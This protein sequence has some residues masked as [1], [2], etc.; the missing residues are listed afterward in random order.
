LRLA[1]Q[2]L[3]SARVAPFRVAVES[4]N[5]AF[6]YCIQHSDTFF[7]IT[8]DKPTRFLVRSAIELNT[9]IQ[10]IDSKNAKARPRADRLLTRALS[11][12][13]MHTHFRM[14]LSSVPRNTLAERAHTYVLTVTSKRSGCIG[15][16]RKLA[17]E[18][19]LNEEMVSLH[20]LP[21][22]SERP[23]PPDRY[24]FSMPNGARDTSSIT[25]DEAE[26][27]DAA[28]VATAVAA[29]A[30]AEVERKQPVVDSA[31][32]SLLLYAAGL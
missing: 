18:V 17:G 16:C 14:V 23:V 19:S 26:D 4:E 11:G 29:G 21:D 32:M 20:S 3:P 8:T 30:A 24:A 13:R 28:P 12:T 1:R 31:R 15:M 6:L 10:F 27:S 2:E 5:D 22:A 7:A 25:T 9:D